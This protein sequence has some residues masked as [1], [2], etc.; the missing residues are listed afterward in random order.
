MSYSLGDCTLNDAQIID[1]LGDIWKKLRYPHSASAIL[2][3]SPG[4][5]KQLE[6]FFSART[7]VAKCEFLTV[8]LPQAILGIESIDMA[9]TTLHEQKYYAFGSRCEVR[10]LC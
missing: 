6:L 2:I 7:I 1:V 5:L 9:G 10:R 3:E 4:R 8:V